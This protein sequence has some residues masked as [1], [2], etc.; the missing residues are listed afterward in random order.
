MLATFWQKSARHN[1]EILW[2]CIRKH[3]RFVNNKEWKDTKFPHARQPYRLLRDVTLWWMIPR[4]EASIVYHS[5]KWAH[6]ILAENHILLKR[7]IISSREKETRETPSL[8]GEA[9]RTHDAK[10]LFLTFA[11][12]PEPMWSGRNIHAFS[13]IQMKLIQRPTK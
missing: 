5:H 3:D 11:S 12:P 1:N 2:K 13:D 8:S 6:V 9:L 4:N 10:K 7:R